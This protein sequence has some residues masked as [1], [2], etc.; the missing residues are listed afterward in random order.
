MDKQSLLQIT[1]LLH[2]IETSLYENNGELSDDLE[3]QLST[4]TIAKERKVDAYFAVLERLKSIDQEFK[5]KI[6]LLTKSAKNVQTLQDRLKSNLKEAMLASSTN[7]LNGELVRFKLST[8]GN[9]VVVTHPNQIPISYFKEV[10]TYD[11]DKE[12][13]KADLI[14]GTP[15]GGC[16]LQPVHTLRTYPST[17][18]KKLEGDL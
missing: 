13:V 14:S 9:K 11:L 12:R 10:V 17:S 5:S 6:D 3:N 8:G 2:S 16:I 7:E 18:S 15:V 1:Q 4:T